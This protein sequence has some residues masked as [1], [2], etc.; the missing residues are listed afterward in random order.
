MCAVDVTFGKSFAHEL[1]ENGGDVDF[2]LHSETIVEIELF[3]EDY[4]A[5]TFAERNL[6]RVDVAR[7]AE[8]EREVCVRSFEEI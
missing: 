3:V 6:T 7:N 5:E 2:A 1:C 8:S 4:F